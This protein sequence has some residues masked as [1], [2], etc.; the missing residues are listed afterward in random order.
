MNLNPLVI[1]INP[2]HARI[3]TYPKW[4]CRHIGITVIDKFNLIYHCDICWSKGTI[5]V[6]SNEGGQGSQSS[7]SSQRSHSSPDNVD[8]L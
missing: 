1:T 6:I 2:L 7:Q 4:T 5:R 3:T 8:R